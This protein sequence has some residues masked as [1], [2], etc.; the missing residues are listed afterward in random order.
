MLSKLAGLVVL[1]MIAPSHISF[2][3][4][5][6]ETNPAASKPGTIRGDYCI[7]VLAIVAFEEISVMLSPRLAVTS[8][9]DQMLWNLLSMRL[10]SGSGDARP[11][12]PL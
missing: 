7:Q 6:G 10:G 5:L 4:M 2:R 9:T 11:L 12:F 8:A 1:E 3:V